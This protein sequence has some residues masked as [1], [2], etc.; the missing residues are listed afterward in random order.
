MSIIAKGS[1]LQRA[2]FPF[3]CWFARLTIM[4]EPFVFDAMVE[5]NRPLK[6]AGI[7][8]V[9]GFLAASSLA[10]SL[11]FVLKGAWPVTPFFGADVLF[12]AIAMRASVKASRR[13]ERLVLTPERL[14]IERIAASGAMRYEEINPYWLRVEHDD[15]E[16]MGAELALVSRGRRWIV[17]SCLGAAERA[18]LADALRRALREARTNGVGR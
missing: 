15:P 18:S 14:R 16:L 7:A 8:L 10:L 17:G 12:L 3:F 2:G 5:P 1:L 9:I 6:P 13:R 11:M 4:Q